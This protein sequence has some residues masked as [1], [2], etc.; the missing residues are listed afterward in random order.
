MSPGYQNVEVRFSQYIQKKVNYI[1]AP[2]IEKQRK[3][4]TGI[5]SSIISSFQEFEI[6]VIQLPW[7]FLT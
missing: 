5:R 3:D 7:P 2:R 6:L 4:Q 1:R